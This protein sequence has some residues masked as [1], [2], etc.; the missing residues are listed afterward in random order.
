[1][2]RKKG[3]NN[4]KYTID[5]KERIIKEY[6]NGNYGLYYYE[7]KYKIVYGVLHSWYESYLKEGKQGLESKT[8]KTGN[9][10]KYKR[11]Q[12]EIE[13]LKEELLK[14]DIELMRLKK[15]YMAKGVG[16]KK[17]FVSISDQIMK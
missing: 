11:K 10:G 16:T 5:E 13:K 15:G 4:R 9:S 6:L 3:G 17:E 14:K 2:A 8:G 12:S 1:M 7:K